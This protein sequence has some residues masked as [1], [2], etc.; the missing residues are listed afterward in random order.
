MKSSDSMCT[1]QR[2][3]SNSHPPQPWASVHKSGLRHFLGILQGGGKCLNG[4]KWEG[5]GELDDTDAL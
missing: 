2:T 4:G 5:G 3:Y 1:V